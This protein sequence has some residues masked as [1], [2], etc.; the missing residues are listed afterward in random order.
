MNLLL[1]LA[2]FTGNIYLCSISSGIIPQFINVMQSRRLLCVKEL[3]SLQIKTSHKQPALN[4]DILPSIQRVPQLLIYDAVVK[5]CKF[6]VK[7]TE[8]GAR[9]AAVLR[10]EGKKAEW[11]SCKFS[12]ISQSV[13]L[14]FP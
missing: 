2:F 9:I 7:Y 3:S 1:T 14:E 8:E 4:M 12:T 11:P 5:E 10:E 13:P 6:V